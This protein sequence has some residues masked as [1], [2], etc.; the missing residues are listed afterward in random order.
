MMREG[1]DVKDYFYISD[2]GRKYL[3]LREQA[4]AA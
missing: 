3:R 2:L 4:E 1:G